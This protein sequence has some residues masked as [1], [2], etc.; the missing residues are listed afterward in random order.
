MI[1]NK[2][3]IYGK[4]WEATLS[5]NGKY[6]DL[7]MTTSEKDD[8]GNYKNSSWFPRAIGHAA[9]SLKNV[10]KGDRITITKSKFT[11]EKYEDENGKK[12]SFFRFLI[13]EASISNGK[14]GDGEEQSV[15]STAATKT[16]AKTPSK[17][18]TKVSEAPDDDCPW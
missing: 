14:E 15:N 7:Q 6:I 18:E 11:N 10:K 1:F 16:E 3:E 2:N 9:N 8:E 12:R 4:V 5:E 13:L 17:E